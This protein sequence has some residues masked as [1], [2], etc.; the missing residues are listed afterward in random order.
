MPSMN[1]E[2]P[3]AKAYVPIDTDVVDNIEHYSSDQIHVDI[4]YIDRDG[5][6][7]H[8]RGFIADVYTTKESEEF[9]KMMDGRT[10]RLDQLVA[11]V[12]KPDKS[13]A[14]GRDHAID[15]EERLSIK[16]NKFFPNGLG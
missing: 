1:R 15:L 4:E 16:D 5:E 12:P 11:V 8:M 6:S 9:L 7:K 10:L 13:Q 3:L 2:D 14:N